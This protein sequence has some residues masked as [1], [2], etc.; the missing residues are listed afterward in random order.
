M[1]VN[2]FGIDLGTYNIK[3]YN[4]FTDRIVSHKNMIAIQNRHNLF[5]YGDDAFT[6]YE[7]SPL[8]FSG[9][10]AKLSAIPSILPLPDMYVLLPSCHE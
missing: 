6:M 3:I 10:N 4:G 1:A 9:S 2:A 8:I 5:A 7:K